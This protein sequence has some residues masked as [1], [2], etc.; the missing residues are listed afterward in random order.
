MN[1]TAAIAYKAEVVRK[2]I[3]ACSLSI[4][5]IYF[6]ISRELALTI[7]APLT[8]AFLAVDLTRYYHK[9]TADLFYRGFRWMLRSHEL[10]EDAK[11]LNGATNVL[12]A[13]TLCVLIF[14]KLIFITAFTILIVSDSM[15]ALIGRRWGR[16]KF[17]TKSLEGSLAFFLSAIAVVLIASTVQYPEGEYRLAA[18]GYNVWIGLAGAAIGTVVEALPWKVDDNLSI[19][20]GVGVSMWIL[21]LIAAI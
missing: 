18:H 4:P 6:F 20:I 14:P 5:I 7:L 21:Y 17:L 16:H 13:A 12:I 3:H 10:D 2:A 11:H 19:P 8:I 1:E 15:A 9:P